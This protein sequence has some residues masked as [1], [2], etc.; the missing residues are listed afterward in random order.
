MGSEDLRKVNRWVLLASPLGCE[1]QDDDME[2]ER[3]DR[4][5]KPQAGPPVGFDEGTDVGGER[6]GVQGFPRC[7]IQVEIMTYGKRWEEEE[8]LILISFGLL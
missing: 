4:F 2:R 5:Q 7:R 6:R 8:L 3:S 1:R